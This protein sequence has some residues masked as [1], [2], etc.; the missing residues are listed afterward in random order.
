MAVFL[1]A[2]I[3]STSESLVL[4][5]AVVLVLLDHFKFCIIHFEVVEASE[6]VPLVF[7]VVRGG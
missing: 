3:E 7:V 4:R 6:E 1:Y 5:L 2:T